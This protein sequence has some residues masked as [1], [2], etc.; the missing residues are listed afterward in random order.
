VRTVP[1]E[2]RPLLCVTCAHF[3]LLLLCCRPSNY[4]YKCSRWGCQH[5]KPLFQLTSFAF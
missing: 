5:L 1:A 3:I 4:P 2:G